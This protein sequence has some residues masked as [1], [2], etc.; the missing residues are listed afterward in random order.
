MNKIH[1][2]ILLLSLP[3]IT[4]SEV[5][6]HSENG[7]SIQIQAEVSVSTEQ[8][9]QQFIQVNEWWDKSHT[10]FGDSKGLSIKAK[11]G[12]CFCEKNGKRQA[13]HM[14][15][16]YVDP[17]HEIRMIGGLGPLQAMGIHG[18]MVWKFEPI[19]KHH[20]KIIHTY[21]VTGYSKDGLDSLASIVDQVQT[22]QVNHLVKMLN[23]SK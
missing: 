20:S 15:V 8:A 2:I 5:L 13:L 22:I 23:T 6:S 9:Y 3:A 18:G 17:N 11:V 19:D 10:W 14:T 4:H 7:F 16:S 12:G 21:N 1:L